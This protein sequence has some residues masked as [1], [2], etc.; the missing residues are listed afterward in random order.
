MLQLACGQVC[1][2]AGMD[3]EVRKHAATVMDTMLPQIRSAL[4]CGYA[5]TVFIVQ[6]DKDKKRLLICMDMPGFY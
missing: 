5:E 6:L 4:S 3:A 2:P 1:A